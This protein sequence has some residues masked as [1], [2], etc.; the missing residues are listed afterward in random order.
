MKPR[1]CA[2]VL[3]TT[4]VLLLI[5]LV[6]NGH[7]P[8]QPTVIF[9]HAEFPDHPLADFARGQVGILQRTWSRGYL[10]VYYRYLSGHPLNAAEQTS[11]L[12]QRDLHAAAALRPRPSDS[13]KI[14]A[15]FENAPPQRWVRARA[16]FRTDKPPSG[17]GE[18]WWDYQA[19]GDCLDDSFLTAI[20]TLR[21]RA[22]RYGAHSRELQEWINA[23]DQVYQNCPLEKANRPL[24]GIIP[25]ELPSTASALAR[26]DRA[27]QIAAAHFYAN[28]SDEAVRRFSEIARD[29]K[30]PW[31]DTA[32]YLVART[33][34]R[35]A[36]PSDVASPDPKRLMQAD[37]NLQAA[38]AQITDRHLKK[39]LAGLRQYVALRLKPEEQ[40][41]VLAG[42]ISSGGSGDRFGQD[43]VDLG[44][45]IDRA[46]GSTPDFPNVQPWTAKYLK[47]AEEWR[48]RRYTEIETARTTSDLTDWVMTVSWN[49]PAA[50]QHA[51]QHWQKRQS[52]PWLV[53]ALLVAHGSD[54]VTASLLDA[55]AHVAPDSPAYPTAVLHRARL[56]RERG[57]VA[58]A[59]R[60]LEEALGRSKDWPVSVANQFKQERLLVADSP[61]D[62][63]RL[64]PQQP[65]GFDNGTVTKGESEYCSKDSGYAS[66]S[67]VGCEEGVLEGGRP[68]RLLPQIDDLS[69]RILNEK[70]PLEL[71][72][73]VAQ[74]EALPENLQKRIAPAVWAR[75]VVLDRQAEAAKIAGL[76]ATARPELKPY[77]DEYQKAASP[78]E[79]KFLG[80]YAIAHF[81][82]LRPDVNGS[83][84]RITRFDYAD[85][86]RDNW[87]C[88][89]GEPIEFHWWSDFS[90]PPH[91]VPAITFLSAQERSRAES[92][93]RKIVALGPAGDWLSNV[94]I[95]WAKTHPQDSKSP[96]A[97]HFAW[98]VT[99]YS[100]DGKANRSRE[101]YI[102]LHRRYPNSVWTRKTRVWW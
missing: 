75:A 55:A 73:A 84:P 68:P 99:R 9:F 69:A 6:V 62:F 32:A 95:D 39:S 102:L 21:N 12:A 100:C 28:N 1:L 20:R 89:S 93:F 42:K 3:L 91:P 53:A 67:S 4:A 58:A 10:V 65:V 82:G 85:N 47:K 25:G 19:G 72:V 54:K 18:D 80:A 24:N 48:N 45:L 33:A 74:S 37:A 29:I 96:E 70:A 88:S 71:L 83:T 78:E 63:A 38:S 30:S 77:I 81:P 46:T 57:E 98:R 60:V 7:S 23:Q 51:I 27:Y 8:Y 44:Y 22:R 64:L 40:F 11:F 97:L 31:H 41:H 35:S 59:R 86:Y 92:E 17:A 49:T 13:W 87:W 101:V 2:V 52:L 14:G 94:L 50:A 36:I 43:V 15:E 16:Q 34:F 66:D 90:P 76:A 56:L 26:A 61:D 79:R 5:P